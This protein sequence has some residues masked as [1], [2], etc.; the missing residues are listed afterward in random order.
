[1][2][3]L[4]RIQASFTEE[5]VIGGVPWQ[6]W[7]D[8][9]WP[10]SIGGP[11]HPSRMYAGAEKALALTPLYA[12]TKILSENA[13]SLPIQ[14]Y[15]QGDD[16][17]MRY[18]GP[19][20]FEKPSVEGTI[21][22]WMHTAMASLILHGN[23][24][25]LITG[26]DK[27][28]FPTGIEWQNPEYIWV[29]EDKYQPFNPLKAKIFMYGRRIPRD[30]LFHVKGFS[31]PGRIEGISVI[32]Q[33]A[34]TILNGLVTADY[35]L[36]W[37]E[38]GGFPTG[39]LQ[40]TEIEVDAEQSSEM[41][42]YLK[43]VLRRHQP[44]V[45][46]RDWDFKTVTVP[47]NEAQFIQAMQL[48]A[49][50]IAALLNLPPDRVGG[51][52]GDSLTYNTQEQSSL[53]I[54]D[55]LRP[56]LVRLESAFFD[57]LPRRRYVRF[58]TDALLKTDLKTRTDIYQIWRQIGLVTVDEIRQEMGREPLP[59]GIGSEA[60]PLVLM[61]AMGTR[62]GGIPKTVMP[63]VDLEMDIATDRLKRLEKTMVPY[64]GPPQGAG[65]PGGQG[66]ATGQ[67]G[68]STNPSAVQPV[69]GQVPL[70]KPNVP[71]PLT[72]DPAS[73][74][75]SL[76]SVQRD[77]GEAGFEAARYLQKIEKRIK[78]LEHESVTLQAE[79]EIQ[80][81]RD[82]QGDIPEING[83]RLEGIEAQIR[84]LDER[85]EVPV[86]PEQLEAV[87]ERPPLDT[88]A[89]TNININVGERAA[90]LD[91]VPGLPKDSGMVYLKV[92]EGKL[93]RPEGG[94]KNHHI[95]LAYLGQHVS[96]EDFAKAKKATRDAAHSTPQ[97]RADIG[98]Q[99]SFPPSD[100]AGGKRVD[101]APVDLDEHG[102]DLRH[103]LAGLSKSD[104]LTWKPHVTLKYS[105]PEDA[106]LS[107]VDTRHVIFTHVHV[108]RGNQVSSYPLGESGSSDPGMQAEE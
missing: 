66:G 67:N 1:V 78:L 73:F 90:G 95:T 30:Q 34:E 38:A 2:D 50:Q 96:D 85:K 58:N 79:M 27:Y 41:R 42:E 99:A 4:S 74:L 93:P 69:N 91:G 28:G 92:P 29:E 6:P 101:Y 89:P 26:K 94:P 3:F 81:F 13:A 54:I 68:I 17:D 51:V 19:S 46:G 61:N 56:W 98:G 82:L 12:G 62:A 33:F 14:I 18:T 84:R 63:Y 70:G 71:P 80:K 39:I 59:G 48:N 105:D 31:I 106:P 102:Y 83:D 103:K 5:R 88:P 86:E 22:D 52:R 65:G 108:K 64:Q 10:F 7:T 75:A 25:G 23:A 44:L 60:M 104:H 32:R 55:A 97:V 53:Q 49:T 24:W 77:G 57:L 87:L 36:S 76:I 47:P 100:P 43:G 72:Q 16:R 37:F 35:G 40:N 11:T 45:L 107:P 20:I 15:I 8:V 21:F 9:R